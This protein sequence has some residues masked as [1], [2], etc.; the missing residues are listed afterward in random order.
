MDAVEKVEKPVSPIMPI[1]GNLMAN[2]M[3]APVPQMGWESGA[4][5]DFFHNWK[6]G[7]IVKASEREATIAVN[8]SRMVAANLDIMERMMTFSAKIE[9]QFDNFNFNKEMRKSILDKVRTELIEQQL[10][11][12]LL[13][14]EVQLNEVELKIKM[15]QLEEILGGTNGGH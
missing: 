8:K 2:A 12:Q 15:K 9:D 10:K 13:H 14:G 1:M 3:P 6:L 4:I 5:E 11:N 7:R